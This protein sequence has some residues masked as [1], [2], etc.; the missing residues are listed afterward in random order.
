MLP[1]D[2]PSLTLPKSPGVD[3]N[4]RGVCSMI[5]ATMIFATTVGCAGWNWR[6]QGF[7][8]NSAGWAAK[9]R[10]PADAGR[11]SGLDARAQEIE[12]NLGVR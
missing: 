7:G 4:W 9:L 1:A 12:R 10:P 6:G 11:F 8:D 3:P 2:S 5:A